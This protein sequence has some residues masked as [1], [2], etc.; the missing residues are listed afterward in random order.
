MSETNINID[1]LLD[2]EILKAEDIQDCIE[3]VN[4]MYEGCRQSNSSLDTLD[5]SL[6]FL[7]NALE[8][9]TSLVHDISSRIE[10]IKS[11]I[12]KG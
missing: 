5:E 10:K 1:S 3:Q 6:G 2:S 8:E 12:V 7:Q 4:G 9:Y 11:R